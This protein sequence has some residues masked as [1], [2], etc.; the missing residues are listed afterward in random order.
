M[1]SCKL[2]IENKSF[3]ITTPKENWKFYTDT[4]ILL[5]TNIKGKDINW[6]SSIEGFIGCGNGISV[7]LSEGKHVITAKNSLTEKEIEIFVESSES[8]KELI[9]T[10]LINQIKQK[11]YI[12]PGSYQSL[13][14]A[15]SGRAS[16]FRISKPVLERHISD[17]KKN[18]KITNNIIKRDFSI[19]HSIRNPL[20]IDKEE[21]NRSIVE[22]IQNQKDF[23]VINTKNQLEM[24]HVLKSEI[25]ISTESYDLWK[26]IDLT[27]NENEI[28]QLLKNL[29]QLIL[30][31]IKEVFGNWADVNFDGKIAI[32]MCPSLNMEKVAIGYF[33]PADL[34][35]RNMDVMSE[36]Y[37]PYSN[38]MDIVY[39]GIPNNLSTDSYNINS[40]SATLAH[41]ITHAIIFNQKTYKHIL[42]GN[43]NRPQEELFLDEGLCHLSE[44]LC[45]FGISG[46]NIAFLSSFLEDT[47]LTSFCREN[48]YFQEDS[49]GQRGAMLLFLSWLY[50]NHQEKNSFIRKILSSD[51]FGWDCI[52]EAY[53]E[54]TDKLF[55]M[56]LEDIAISYQQNKKFI[57]EVNTKTGEP[58]YFFCNMGNYVFNE[59][60]YEIKFPKVY[61]A[62][63]NLDILPYSFRFIDSDIFDN[64][65]P[66]NIECA[67]IK[68]SVFIGFFEKF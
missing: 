54:R 33:N 30:P 34:F 67:S 14:Y 25:Y 35:K 20:L 56:F 37:N 36:S 18:K 1:I 41:E 68:D 66:I 8:R 64:T 6:Y 61:D 21:N 27:L 39:I 46:G 40:V 16:N 12:H 53:G 19:N 38:E 31:C 3:E 63:E 15:L 42:L 5:S 7:F 17:E 13:T 57:S 47:A 22:A 65:S 48:F 4:P 11:I 29:E 62:T 44:N 28:I 10:Y 45:G 55:Q 51:K 24:P 58:M 9:Y 59:R 50:R 23:F 26:P 32:L 60:V 49:I 43:N 2:N 52:G